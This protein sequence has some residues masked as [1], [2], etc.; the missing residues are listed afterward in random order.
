MDITAAD[1]FP[2]FCVQKSSY[3]YRSYSQWLQCYG[4]FFK[5]L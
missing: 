2:D 5:F 4:L 1:Y 3:Q